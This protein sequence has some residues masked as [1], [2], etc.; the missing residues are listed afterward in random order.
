M[1]V[2]PAFQKLRHG[3]LKLRASLDYTG[4]HMYRKKDL[5][6]SLGCSSAVAKHFANPVPQKEMKRIHRVCLNTA[7]HPEKD[8]TIAP[9]SV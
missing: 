1:P 4:D 3:D 9:T 7:S 2:I 5:R 6:L 8:A